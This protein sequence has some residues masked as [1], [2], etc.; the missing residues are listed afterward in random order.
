MRLLRPGDFVQVTIDAWSDY[1][2]NARIESLQS[3]TGGEFSALPPQNATSNW[4]KTVQRLPVR[5][6]FE[7]NAFAAFPSRADVAPGMS[8]TARVKVID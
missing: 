2:V 5:I 7:R 1:P 8:V 6:R 4:V 3:G